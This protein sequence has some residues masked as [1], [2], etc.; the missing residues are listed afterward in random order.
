M[1]DDAEQA[2]RLGAIQF[3]AERRERL[4]TQLRIGGGEIDQVTRM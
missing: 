3:I 2:E 4:L 1:N